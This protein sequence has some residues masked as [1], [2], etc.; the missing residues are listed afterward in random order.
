[1]FATVV[2]SVGVYCLWSVVLKK[3]D[4]VGT[5]LGVI[6]AVLVSAAFTRFKRR[7]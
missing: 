1:M 3:S 5:A 4:S 7:K 6:T 2:L